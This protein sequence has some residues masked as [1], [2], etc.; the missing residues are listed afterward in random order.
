[1]IRLLVGLI[2]V[3]LLAL[4]AVQR[5]APRRT[6]AP[7]ATSTEVPPPSDTRPAPELGAK[8]REME[9]T[10]EKALEDSSRA[11]ERALQEQSR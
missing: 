3:A 4:L 8:L 11:R 9:D 6:E 10:A 1:M 7:A 2:V 5:M